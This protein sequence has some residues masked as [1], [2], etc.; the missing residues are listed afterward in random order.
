[1]INLY[2]NMLNNQDNSST[3][4]YFIVVNG[5]NN[6]LNIKTK[7]LN[8]VSNTDTNITIIGQYAI[9]VDTLLLIEDEVMKVISSSI[10]GNNTDISVQRAI[11]GTFA[12]SHS[13]T[14]YIYTVDYL[15]NVD[16]LTYKQVSN[17]SD[18]DLFTVNVETGSFKLLDNP[19][20]WALN[21][22]NKKW[23]WK[24]NSP[25]FIFEGVN[26][27]FVC[28]Y[29]GVLTRKSPSISLKEK[30][31]KFEFKNDLS[32]FY[33]KKPSV[34]KFYNNVSIDTLLQDLF[35]N[36]TIQL[37]NETDINN[38]PK[39]TNFDTGKF[40]T[41]NELLNEISKNT[42]TRIRFR[43]NNTIF[44]TNTFY[45]NNISPSVT[46]DRSVI[47]VTEDDNNLLMF[48][49]VK[50]TFLN[51]LPYY[52]INEFKDTS[53][54]IR[55]VN[56]EANDTFT[57]PFDI[58]DA[59]EW[60]SHTFTAVKSKYVNY[61]DYVLLIDN[62]TRNEFWGIVSDIINSN[63]FTVSFGIEKDLKWDNLG[64]ITKLAPTGILTLHNYT[65]YYGKKEMPI[66]WKYSRKIKDEDKSGDLER[67]I[68]P[69]IFKD[70]VFHHAI[71]DY[72]S[73]DNKISFNGDYTEF[74]Q[75]I[76]NQ[77]TNE[78]ME[79]ISSD[80][81]NNTTTFYVNRGALDTVATN[82]ATTDNFSFSI[83]G[84]EEIYG[85]FN[86]ADIGEKKFTGLV[87]GIDGI[88]NTWFDNTKLLYNKE[89]KQ[90]SILNNNNPIPIY[91]YSNRMN[92]VSYNQITY[93]YFD[94]SNLKLK[95]E[96]VNDEDD[97]KINIHNN[98][99]FQYNNLLFARTPLY[100]NRTLIEVDSSTYDYINPGGV[101]YLNEIPPNDSNY[102]KYIELKDFT[103]TILN[104][105]GESGRYYLL[106][107]FDYPLGNLEFKY[108]DYSKIV[109]LNE[110]Y[111]RGNPIME[112]KENIKYIDME[113]IDL[114]DEEK[115]YPI[116]TSY[117]SK[118]DFQKTVDY[119]KNGFKA[120]SYNN[121]IKKINF[122]D[123]KK[124]NIEVLDTIYFTENNYI[125][126]DNQ[127][128]IVIEKNVSYNKGK[129]TE[130]IVALTIG[131]YN[132]NPK[133][134]KYKSSLDYTT[135]NIPQY[136]WKSEENKKV[137]DTDKNTSTINN[138]T[139]ASQLVMKSDKLLGQVYLAKY[140]L[141]QIKGRLKLGTNIKST[142]KNI[143]FTIDTIT[144]TNELKTMLFGT[145]DNFAKE[146]ILKINNEFIYCKITNIT[147]PF[148]EVT[149]QSIN[150][151][152]FGTEPAEM[153]SE[154]TVQIYGIM[155]ILGKN[156][157]YTQKA[158]MGN[159]KDNY[160]VFNE[161]GLDI[162]TRGNIHIENDNNTLHFDK[163][164][165]NESYLEIAKNNP[166]GR[167]QV[168]NTTSSNYLKWE[169]GD[170]DIASTGNVNISNNS[171]ALFMSENGSS[172]LKLAQNGANGELSVGDITSNNYIKYTTTDGLQFKGK[173]FNGVLYTNN[174]EEFI[175]ALDV[176]LPTI[177]LAGSPIPNPF[178]QRYDINTIVISGTLGI[179]GYDI[180]IM[181]KGDYVIKPSNYIKNIFGSTKYIQGIGSEKA[182]IDFNNYS[183]NIGYPCTIKDLSFYNVG[184][185]NTM[186]NKLNYGIIINS[187]EVSLINIDIHDLNSKVINNTNSILPTVNTKNISVF[188]IN[189]NFNG[190]SIFEN[191]YS[192]DNI[193]V[194]IVDIDL[195][196][197]LH[198]FLYCNNLSNV[199]AQIKGIGINGAKEI[200]I[201]YSS[202]NITNAIIRLISKIGYTIMFCKNVSNIRIEN[203]DDIEF[204]MS[205]NISNIYISPSSI[206]SITLSSIYNISNVHTFGDKLY[207]N[208]N[209]DIV[210]Y[211]NCF[212][213]SFH[214][215]DTTNTT[216]IFPNFKNKIHIKNMGSPATVFFPVIDEIN[217]EKILYIKSDI[218]ATLN[219]T[220][221]VTINGASTKNITAGI[222]GFMYDSANSNW[223]Q[224]LGG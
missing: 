86:F 98:S 112:K 150:R 128:A 121:T 140:D 58:I 111:I 59:S 177:N 166:L 178:Y 31:L 22:P 84:G 180:D 124:L 190:H 13:V 43:K 104:K 23:T 215:I 107:D 85:K 102:D 9:P 30:S 97:F 8:S 82:I 80:Y 46:I 221:D 176:D 131:S 139:K 134:I 113:S 118:I 209:S 205:Y 47:E 1:M 39:L 106:L 138:A 220:D 171:N 42:M 182:Q 200:D 71:Q 155:S 156:G 152:L 3:Q 172:Y 149:V 193:Y 90:S 27:E 122:K 224:I 206:S 38:Y 65:L 34:V 51:R 15:E 70:N 12:L 198:I 74:N 153:R 103:W 2:G 184:Q 163:D 29:Q 173:I 7:L 48:N 219:A 10:N 73:T 207:V 197:Y 187:N 50:G 53:N 62:N 120:T 78:Y 76:Y 212:W 119:I 49:G 63:S 92:G 55:Y 159:G 25:V 45:P 151:G 196:S 79:I 44:I 88:Y 126:Y 186:S 170:L 100:T 214:T 125:G 201:F 77:T 144:G 129:R 36:Y 137:D 218:S 16:N 87:G 64:K 4:S 72:N 167:L 105:F 52:D 116:N 123:V 141:S 21:N 17:V 160:L 143:R 189:N 188:N 40:N 19:Y 99:Q 35:P 93:R 56:F 203:S 157:L 54:N 26:G 109:F 94:N 204:S 83:K 147:N 37:I 115:F 145:Y 154:N 216:A 41:I 108:I 165:N 61:S 158:E 185:D 68:L 91:L 202:T 69:M 183:F 133:N 114:Y 164:D 18:N 130:S 146:L 32:L 175:G 181:G 223:I 162:S 14:S 6:N 81:S 136:D 132:I 28:T 66:V 191:F 60:Q 195:S 110:L 148:N 142:D 33:N 89:Y 11:L 222:Y 20:N 211:N 67:P 213:D 194:E 127:K 192:M 24:K 179:S 208:E 174:T 117:L 169:N 5:I 217:E 135:I 96:K 199:V 95:I 75:Y 161:S 101:I 57:T 168:G 210:K